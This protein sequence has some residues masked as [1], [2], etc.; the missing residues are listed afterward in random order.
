[1]L[2][3]IKSSMNDMSPDDF[4]STRLCRTDHTLCQ[5]HSDW[6]RNLINNRP[7]ALQSCSRGPR[8]TLRT[9]FKWQDKPIESIQPENL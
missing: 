9:F 1:M 5:Q 3:C 2:C 6:T 4:M 8:S 7:A